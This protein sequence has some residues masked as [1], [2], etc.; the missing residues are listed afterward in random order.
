MIKSDR[1]SEKN[2][3]FHEPITYEPH[4]KTSSEQ[5]VTFARHKYGQVGVFRI[6][7]RLLVQRV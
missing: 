5:E 2:D 4:V 7:M 1:N 3:I 6:K